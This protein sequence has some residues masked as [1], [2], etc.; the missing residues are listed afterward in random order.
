MYMTIRGSGQQ[1]FQL[2]LCQHL[3]FNFASFI[4]KKS[5]ECRHKESSAHPD[6]QLRIELT[7]YINICVSI[8][9]V[10]NCSEYVNFTEVIRS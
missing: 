1:Q 8:N 6:K 3:P 7:N 2:G 10:L 9:T 5:R 4:L